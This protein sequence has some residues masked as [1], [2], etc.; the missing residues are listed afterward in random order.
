MGE[1]VKLGRLLA[2]VVQ[3]IVLMYQGSAMSDGVYV[4][5]G[6]SI[7]ICTFII[8]ERSVEALSIADCIWHSVLPLPNRGKLSERLGGG[9]KGVRSG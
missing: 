1:T 5:G 2:L 9:W 6:T 8:T 7:I 3:R 4:L